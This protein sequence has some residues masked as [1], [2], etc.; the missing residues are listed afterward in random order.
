MNPYEVNFVTFNNLYRRYFIYAQNEQEAVQ[1]TK[2]V[3]P[4]LSEIISI[5]KLEVSK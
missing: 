3:F 4:R 1:E 2:K 5:N